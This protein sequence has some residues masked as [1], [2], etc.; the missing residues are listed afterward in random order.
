MKI[1][2]IGSGIAGLSAAYLLA[3]R[4]DVTVFEQDARVGG[5]TNTGEVQTPDGVLAID[6]GFIV[7]NPVNY[8]N[9][10][11]LLDELG[12]ARQDTDMSLGVSIEDGRVEWA[13]DENLLKVFAQPSLIL[14][15]THWKMLSAITS[16]NTPIRSEEPKSE[17][18]SLM[19]ITYEV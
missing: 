19:R 7:C 8:P 1:A 18:Q 14:S 3:R 10:Y 13:G 17:L 9:C 12:V 16:F 6:T 15:P 2:V 11:A 5:H 4:H